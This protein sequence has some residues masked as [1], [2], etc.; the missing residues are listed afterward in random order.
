MNKSIDSILPID[1]FEQQFVLIKVM[2]QSPRLEYHMK[3]IGI[4]QSLINRSSFEH[5]CLN[6]IKYIYQHAG[7]RYYQQNLKDLLDADMV[8]TPE[9][10]TDVISSLRKTP[11]TVKK[12]RARKSLCL[13]TNI[14]YVKNK[15][16]KRRVGAE[17][18]K[19]IAV[20]VGNSL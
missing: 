8:S 2:L 4:N 9:E 7:K 6:N 1:T 16:S 17:K 11:T 3:T 18:P 5:K 10:I 15:A 19:R 13:F 12:P 20:K 14:F